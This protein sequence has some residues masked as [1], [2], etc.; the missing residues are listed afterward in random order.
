[1]Y[2]RNPPGFALQSYPN[3]GSDTIQSIVNRPGTASA[4]LAFQ[5]DPNRRDAYVQQWHLTSQYEVLP[6][7]LAG[8]ELRRH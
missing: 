3:N 1:M 4:A 5:I 8:S 6:G 7:L 2:A